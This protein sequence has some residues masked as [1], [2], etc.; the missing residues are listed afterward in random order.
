MPAWLQIA[1]IVQGFWCFV[2]TDVYDL[3]FD[4]LCCVRCPF[5]K[6]AELGMHM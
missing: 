4:K 6:L 2:A 3:P 1:A 5:D